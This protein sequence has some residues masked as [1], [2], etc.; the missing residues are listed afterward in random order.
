VNLRLFRNRQLVLVGAL[1]LGSGICEAVILFVPSLLVAA[2]AVTP[3]TASF[4]VIPMV[5]GMAVGSPFSGRLLDTS[6]SRLVVLIGSVLLTA[7][8]IIIGLFATSLPFYYVFAILFG[9]G[10][11]V[12]LGASLRYIMLNEV[13]GS[14]R[15]SAQGLLTIFISIGQLVGAA[16]MGAVVAARGG[17][18]G[19]AAAFL[20]SGA[21]MLILTIASTQLKSR[22]AELE[23]VQRN[24]VTA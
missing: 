16:L 8:L 7:S 1:A 12:L 9:I 6:G 23:T 19:Y 10:I 15:A 21:V 11:G 24:Q 5:I 13:T 20:A 18:D 4:M 22:A 17:I 3:A 14:E 2:F